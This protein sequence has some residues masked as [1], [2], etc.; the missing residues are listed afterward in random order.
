MKAIIIGMGIQGNKRKKFLKKDF[1]F[2]VDK[3]KKAD[4]KLVN[5][6]PIN[7]YDTAFVC[8][9]DSEKYKIIEFCLKNKK[10]V[11][12]EKPL[13]TESK[14]DLI[15][16]ENLAK[17]NKTVLYT[18]Y[19]HRFEPNIIELKKTIKKRT[20]GKIFK[21]RIFYGNGTS[22]LVKKSKWRD[23]KLGVITDIGSHLIDICL[24]LF[25]KKVQKLRII[26][27][28][29]FENKAPDHAILSLEMNGIKIELEMTLCMWKNTF[30]C[31]LIGNKG[32]AHLNSLCKWSKSSFLIRKRKFP[33]GKPLEKIKF[34]KRG[35][36]TWK[37]ENIYFKK[38]LRNKTFHIKKDIILNDEFIKLKKFS[39]EKKK[40]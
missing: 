27:I 3:F 2:S 15:R 37:K 39:N 6:V 14:K 12:V 13:I 23:K 5:N 10:N 29:K 19:N 31:D 16:L 1:I 8:T 36:P 18:A 38:I 4:F 7:T 28:N 9:P 40:N 17:K 30:T 21:C 34:F 22:Y 35:D 26:E 25:D 24:F 32:S 20:L 33:S 11:L